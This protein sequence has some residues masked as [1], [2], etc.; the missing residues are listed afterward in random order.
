MR[1]SAGKCLVLNLINKTVSLWP[2]FELNMLYALFFPF[3][4][5]GLE[6][7][8]WNGVH[9]HKRMHIPATSAFRV[10][11]GRDMGEAKVAAVHANLFTQS[12]NKK[13]A[14]SWNVA[15]FWSVWY[16]SVSI[17]PGYCSGTFSY[18]FH[19]LCR[20]HWPVRFSRR[21]SA[22]DNFH[23]NRFTSRCST[24]EFQCSVRPWI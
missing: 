21:L 7:R 20:Q 18:H 17:S 23:L 1:C 4:H 6:N 14:I 10:T 13:E 8:R 11:L 12:F 15:Y 3:Q 5:K 2:L 19:A 22:G 24:S 16:H 9:C